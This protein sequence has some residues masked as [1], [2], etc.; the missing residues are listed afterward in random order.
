M[1]NTSISEDDLIGIADE[2]R[3]RQPD[4][5]PLELMTKLSARLLAHHIPDKRDRLLAGDYDRVAM[6]FA[7]EMLRANDKPASMFLDEERQRKHYGGIEALLFGN[8]SE[9]IFEHYARLLGRSDKP[10]PDPL[11]DD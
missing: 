4:I 10:A 11:F 3:S 9:G 5:T 6:T 1:S 7:M 2:L 8:L